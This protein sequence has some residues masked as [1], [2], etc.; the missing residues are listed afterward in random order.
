LR[1]TTKS[2]AQLSAGL[3]VKG[4]RASKKTRYRL[5]SVFTTKE[6]TQHPD[7]DAQFGHINISPAEFLAAGLPVISVDT[8]KKELVG[9]YAN[10]GRE[11]RPTG[12]PVEVN[13][14]DFPHPDVPRAIPYGVYDLVA[15][16]G[17]VSVG[18]DRDTAEFAVNTINVWWD[19]VGR[20]R[21]P[22][23]GR[24]MITAATTTDTGLT[25]EAVL[26]AGKYPTGARYTDTQMKAVPLTRDQFHGEWNYTI[27]PCQTTKPLQE[28]NSAAKRTN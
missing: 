8:K 23:A 24:L 20:H 13:G 15:N 21:Y 19:M 2:L 10:K 11:W 22:N 27:S 14:H 26:D 3:V 16:E 7:R 5:Q 6:G 17:F 28:T 9:E 12:T 25:V 1:W 4:F 18:I